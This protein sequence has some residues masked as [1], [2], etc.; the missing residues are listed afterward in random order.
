MKR[1]IKKLFRLFGYTLTKSDPNLTT[2][3]DYIIDNLFNKNL[4]LII[5]DIGA[6]EGQS[7]EK[8][9][10]LYKNATIYSFETLFK[11][12]NI[13]KNKNI[14]NLKPFNIGFSNKK[15]EQK[16]FLNQISDTS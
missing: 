13:L 9:R 14:K 16:F 3:S 6:N 8:Y 12:Y 4:K 15:T 7:A 2:S 11:E 5:F 10:S 1:F